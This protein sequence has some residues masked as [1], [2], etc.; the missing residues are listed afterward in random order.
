MAFDLTADEAQS[1]V[2][3]IGVCRDRAERARDHAE[4]ML[5]VAR[6]LS[7]GA[8]GAGLVD[9]LMDA[10]TDCTSARDAADRAAGLVLDLALAGEA[11]VIAEA[12]SK[13]DEASSFAR[14]ARSALDAIE[15]MATRVQS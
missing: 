2:V 9:L 12:R 6:R 4:A 11:D 8:Q 13:A 5:R 10:R 1:A 7:R 14:S 15:A 3:E